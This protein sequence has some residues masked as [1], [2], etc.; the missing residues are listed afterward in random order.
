MKTRR[1]N[2]RFIGLAL[3]ALFFIIYSVSAVAQPTAAQLADQ[4]DRINEERIAQID[5]LEIVS[6]ITGGM[7]AGMETRSIYEK[8][9]RDGRQVLVPVEVDDISEIGEFSGQFDD[10]MGEMIR[11]ASSIENDTYNGAVVY[12]VTVD[13]QEYLR[14]LGETAAFSAEE[15]D[16]MD[17]EFMPESVVIWIDRNEL[18]TYRVSMKQYIDEDIG[19]TVHIKLS[20]YQNHS[21]L[22]IPHLM[23]MEV[24]GLDDLV[25]DEELAEARRAMAELEEQLEQMPPAQREMIE[26]QLRPQI[27][28]FEQMLEQGELGSARIE[29][30]EVIVN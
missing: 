19:I 30:K 10:M 29:I 6:E 12:R 28:R 25:S 26:Q 3:T 21:G 16:E 4:V 18:I 14:Q 23:E 5:R 24:E 8:S 17:G 15:L 11:H 7:L 9:T 13:D 27:E 22:P 1:M 20:D 2:T